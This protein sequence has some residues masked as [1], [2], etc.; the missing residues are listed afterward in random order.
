MKTA[1]LCILVCCVNAPR[2]LCL[3]IFV[4]CF[5]AAQGVTVLNSAKSKASLW[6]LKGFDE[7]F[8]AA[9]TTSIRGLE[10]L[11]MKGQAAG[12]QAVPGRP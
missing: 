6:D 4:I 1:T 12:R 2:S 7:Q 10:A 5:A 9:R 11:V 3:L 8:E